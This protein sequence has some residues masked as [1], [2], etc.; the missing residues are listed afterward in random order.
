MPSLHP[1]LQQSLLIQAQR[2]RLDTIGARI[3]TTVLYLKAAWADPVLYGG[4]GQR[5][6]G[7][8]DVL[9]RPRDFQRFAN[10]LLKEGFRRH[11]E[12]W[13][14]ASHRLIGKAWLFEPPRDALPV[15]L[16]R[17]LA[18][19]PWFT[20]AVNEWIDRAQFYPSVDGPILSLSPEDQ[21]LY[22]AAHYAN[23]RYN[24]GEQHL[25]D[26]SLLLSRYEVNW[27]LIWLRAKAS[28]LR[29]ALALFVE[30]LRARNASVPS[31]DEDRSFLTVLRVAYAKRQVKLGSNLRRAGGLRVA[32][33][34][35]LMPVLSDRGVALPHYV[36]RSALVRA[37]D[38]AEVVLHGFGKSP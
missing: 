33:M 19:R 37:L 9:V 26:V 7:D 27:R 4:L 20:I 16:H 22:A 28:Q 18:D 25:N 35:L 1:G 38:V 17:D 15:D 12:P 23:H 31:S 8:V 13:H 11:R 14:V 2:R 30:A 3:G 36:A 21:V 34:A 29:V 24:L 32:D 5:V 10:E 6:G